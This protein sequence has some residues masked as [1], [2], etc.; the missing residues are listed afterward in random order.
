LEKQTFSYQFLLFTKQI[1]IRFLS[2]SRRIEMTTMFGQGLGRG[3][4]DASRPRFP[5]QSTR[6]G[7]CHFDGAERLRN[8]FY[9][10]ALNN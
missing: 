6:Q 10:N 8:L 4:A 9:D 3:N 7:L 5:S 2:A 1:K